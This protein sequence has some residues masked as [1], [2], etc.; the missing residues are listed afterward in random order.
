[1]VNHWSASMIDTPQEG[2]RGALMVLP[3][4]RADGWACIAW[5]GRPSDGRHVIFALDGP[6]RCRISAR[7]PFTHRILK[8]ICNAAGKLARFPAPFFS[9]LP[10]LFVA[11]DDAHETDPFAPGMATSTG[12]GERGRDAGAECSAAR[13]GII[14]PAAPGGVGTPG[15]GPESGRHS[16]RA[17]A[18]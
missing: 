18:A 6:F 3:L 8:E 4:H 15:C 16:D 11:C 17:S 12:R 7:W 14:N 13:L 1:M 2:P 10:G 5:G 9:N